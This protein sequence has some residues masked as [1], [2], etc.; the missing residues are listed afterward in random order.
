V[1]LKIKK[2]WVLVVTI[3]LFIVIN[4]VLSLVNI[5]VI[6]LSESR[7]FT[8]SDRT[9]EILQ[10][11]KEPINLYV[12]S[13]KGEDGWGIDVILE[14][15]KRENDNINFEFVGSDG[16]SPIAQKY[17][18]S[19][20]DIVTVVKGD[21]SKNIGHYDLYSYTGELKLES[22]ITTAI[23]TVN[24]DEIKKI[25]FIEGHGEYSIDQYMMYL[26]DSLRYN[27]YDVESI[28]LSKEEL[29]SD[30]DLIVS[31]GA[32]YDLTDNEKQKLLDYMKNGGNMF[33][34]K[35]AEGIGVKTPR[36]DS[37]ISDY[38]INV[39]DEIII[40]KGA[41]SV[42]GNPYL[43]VLNILPHE[44]TNDIIKN[45][46]TIITDIISRPIETIDYIKQSEMGIQIEPIII[47]SEKAYTII[48]NS[49]EDV[50]Y[51]YAKKNEGVEF[52]SYNIGVIGRKNIDNKESKM[53]VLGN[54]SIPVDS[55]I[56]G[57][58]GNLELMSGLINWEIGS[59]KID[60]KVPM[61]WI[62]TEKFD[63]TPQQVYIMTI[64]LFVIPVVII[65]VGIIIVV[66]RRRK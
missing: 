49:L 4:I 11:V 66:L 5:P 10:S 18:E 30:V 15:Y 21:K 60:A 24:S 57:S 51:E 23:L 13:N 35:G 9:K 6:D 37:I 22:E 16:V 47:S 59:E 43:A 39:K 38:G 31:V 55:M 7:M 54:S 41:S 45:N 65:I 29:T 64:L 28:N 36:L 50:V 32:K 52:K 14:N 56:E 19:E 8:I 40:D 2:N 34:V 44:S 26:K 3:L 25:A 20:D 48:T 62:S 61:K 58:V 46:L 53:I 17:K 12:Y 42:Y 63:F 33:V 27:A 1:I